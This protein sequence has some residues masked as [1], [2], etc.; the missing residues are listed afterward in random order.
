MYVSLWY[1]D[2]ASIWCYQ[3]RPFHFL[4]SF[5]ISFFSVFKFWGRDHSP[6]QWGSFLGV[7]LSYWE[8]NFSLICFAASS[9][10][11]YRKTAKF[12]VLI[13]Y[14]ATLLI[15]FMSSKYFLVQ[16]LGSLKYK[17]RPSVHTDNLISL[18]LCLLYFLLLSYSY[19]EDVDTV[20]DKTWE[21]GHLY[22][23][24]RGNHF[25]FSSFITIFIKGLSKIMFSSYFFIVFIMKESWTLLKSFYE[26]TEMIMR[27]LFMHIFMWWIK[28]I[29][30]P[31]LNP[32]C[33]LQS[34][35]LCHGVWTSLYVAW[36]W[37]SRI[38]WEFLYVHSLRRYIVFTLNCQYL[39]AHGCGV[40]LLLNL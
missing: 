31:G 14:P 3:G 17:V 25:D 10:L 30:F 19:S 15:V 24:F 16:S 40:Y 18:L 20:L 7:F 33:I 36:T 22:P 38:Y 4:V 11:V 26:S 1:V 32:S 34:N 23:D 6:S 5:K 35:Q 2:L 21:N 27:Y 13:L 28:R 37:M 29:D 39:C 8:W 9:M 12:C